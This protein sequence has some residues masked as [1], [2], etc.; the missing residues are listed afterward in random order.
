MSSPGSAADSAVDSAGGAPVRPRADSAAESG[1]RPRADAAADSVAGSA[2]DSGDGAGSRSAR[3]FPVL[4]AALVARTRRFGDARVEPGG[5]RIAWSEG[6]AGRADLV[7]APLD[8]SGPAVVVTAE[9]AAS[10][11]PG[12]FCW[13]SGGRLVYVTG[14]G[15]LAVT[16]A[17]GGPV[18]A[19]TTD[20]RVAAPVVS[21]DGTRVAFVVER[22]DR[23]DIAWMPLDS[24]EWPVRLS[25]GAA[26]TYD[27]TWSADGAHVAWH[28][29]DDGLMPWDGSRIVVR[30]VADGIGGAD[31]GGGSGPRLVAGGPGT[32]VGQPRFSPDG[33]WLA[34]ISDRTG[35][36]NVWVGRAPFGA[37][38]RPLIERPGASPGASRIAGEAFEHAEATWGPGQRSFAWSPDSSAIALCRNERGFGRLV[39]V[40]VRRGSAV[41]ELARAWHLGL[42]WTTP[43]TIVAVR[44]GGVTVPQVVATPVDGS[45]RRTL[46]RSAPAGIEAALPVEPEIVGWKS[47]DGGR[48]HG[49]LY[50]PRPELG[51]AVAV[52]GVGVGPVTVGRAGTGRTVARPPLL[53]SIHG[54]PTDQ[55]SVQWSGRVQYFVSR[56]WAVLAVNYRGSTGLGRAHT[57]ALNGRW[58]ELDVADVA[59]G[60]REARRRRWIDARRVAVMGGS[61]GGFTALLVALHHAELV[62]ACVALYPVSDLFDLAE[63]THRYEARYLDALVGHLPGAADR[64]EQRSPL[65]HA[66]R[67]KVPL[68]V[69]QGSADPVVPPAQAEALVSAVRSA[70]TPVEHQVYDG[71]GHGWGR[72][73]TVA[74]ELSRVE[75]F[76]TRWVLKR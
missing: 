54:G 62:R 63:T 15:R 42:D 76:L 44:T 12:S 64:Y 2:V 41:K 70:G 65:T 36:A 17:S 56:G 7:V 10:A 27:P 38:A 3:P 5:G 34:W 6:L 33:R 72:P 68:L 59:S 61:A 40:G 53:V 30:G 35:W 16:S 37:G 21:P 26:F 58:G 74:D 31:T 9:T 66:G 52:A 28:E 69:L 18:S 45:P 47:P 51:A 67:L 22:V 29:W 4:P 25:M 13:A 23:C 20:G 71:E 39:T 57:Q 73:E 46:A 11:S 43:E 24:S 49:V 14:D 50:R 32:A 48:V 60:I 1:A 55:H 19:L 8:G 75:A